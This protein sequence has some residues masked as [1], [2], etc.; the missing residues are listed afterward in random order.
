[1]KNIY[2]VFQTSKIADGFTKQL[3][4]NTL[5]IFESGVRKGLVV[6]YVFKTLDGK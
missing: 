3:V 2:L 5:G 1:M 4:E 6:L